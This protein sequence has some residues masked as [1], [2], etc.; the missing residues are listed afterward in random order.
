MSWEKKGLRCRLTS[1]W[2]GTGR[3]PASARDTDMVGAQEMPPHGVALLHS[4]SGMGGVYGTIA[5]TVTE[6]PTR[7]MSG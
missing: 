5:S 7:S 1:Y 3:E 4:A 6:R 2:F